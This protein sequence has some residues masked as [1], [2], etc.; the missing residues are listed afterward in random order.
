MLGPGYGINLVLPLLPQDR[1][2]IMIHRA[3]G[4]KETVENATTRQRGRRKPYV[5]KGC[6]IKVTG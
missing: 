1:E 5:L 2:K 3:R 6:F 4:S